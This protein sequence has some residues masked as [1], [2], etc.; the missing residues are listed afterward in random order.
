MEE[1][2]YLE[3]MKKIYF[4]VVIGDQAHGYECIDFNK[5]CNFIKEFMTDFVAFFN[6]NKDGDIL[7]RVIHKDKIIQIK[8]IG[9]EE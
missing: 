9:T 1:R 2:T 8:N 7:L 5:K 6:S 4:E 3:V